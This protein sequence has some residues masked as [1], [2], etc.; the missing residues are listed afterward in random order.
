MAGPYQL[1]FLSGI[2]LVLSFP[3]FGLSFLAWVALVPLLLAAGPEKPA[4]S[5]LY[6]LVC[7]VVF[8]G[9]AL[10][11]IY[12]A[13]HDFGHM[14]TLESIC[15]L[16]LLVVYLSLF[17]ALFAWGFALFGHGPGEMVFAPALFVLLEYLR[18]NFLSGFPWALL[19]HSQY[20]HPPVIQVAS[21]TGTAGVT[22]LIVLVNASIAHA[23][24]HRGEGRRAIAAPALALSLLAC[25][26]LWGAA[27]VHTL[28]RAGGTPFT[29][30]LVQGNVEQGQK[31]D[32][33]Y[34]DAV[35]QKYF[36]MTK[37]AAQEKPGLIVWP[38]AAA[39]FLYGHNPYYTGMARQVVR[40]TNVPLMF[41]ALGRDNDE[42]GNPR[43]YNR[44]Y[45]AT[46][47]GED[48]M[49][50]KMHLVPFGEYVPFRQALTFAK[51]LTQAVEGDTVPG[52]STEPIKL[53][54]IL[55]GVQ[56]CYEIIFPE[57]SRAFAANG[58]RLIVN[59]TNDA[60]YGH[61]AASAQHM[62]SIPYRAVE[63]RVPILRAANTGISCFITAAGEVRK[64]TG[65]F[66]TVTITDTVIIPPLQPTFY[67]RFGDI[68]TYGCIITAGLSFV[69]FRVGRRK[70]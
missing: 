16:A 64:P 52:T 48:R 13:M 7:G 67:T 30:S 6:G 40:D 49:Y 1:A 19:A 5:M 17:F 2:L 59:I 38:E 37:A 47:G 11:W 12:N 26:V 55:S 54:G 9:G 31:W 24:R 18:G 66:E 27:Q 70:L 22:F 34:Q 57:G 8:F 33:Q 25:N 60:W 68:F 36:D 41:G 51:K 69:L 20:L 61:S 15:L 3:P 58:A 32:P 14:G 46:P 29:A 35:A 62:M 50:D 45:L 23:I 63:N 39:P 10:P 28:E 53:D 43:Y 44:A 56:I 4:S 21:I 65:L 42:S